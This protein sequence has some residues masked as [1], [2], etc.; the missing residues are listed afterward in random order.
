M[1]KNQIAIR[2]NS[3][4]ELHRLFDFDHTRTHARKMARLYRLLL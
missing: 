3:C 1:G 2:F 4:I